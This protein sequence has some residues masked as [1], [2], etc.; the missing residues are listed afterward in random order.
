M[1]PLIKH[2]ATSVPAS[3]AGTPLQDRILMMRVT[4]YSWRISTTH[5]LRPGVRWSCEHGF[6][7]GITPRR[8][9]ELEGH[10]FVELERLFERWAKIDR[11]PMH[12]RH[13]QGSMLRKACRGLCVLA[14]N[15]K[16]TKRSD[17]R[18]RRLRG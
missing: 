11:V 2:D 14:E 17:Q 16:R 15:A 3:G 9:A 12:C 1:V 8:P 7:D 6:L 5:C 18:D 10:V 13:V 4:A